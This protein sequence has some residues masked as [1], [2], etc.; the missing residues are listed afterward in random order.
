MG[1]TIGGAESATAWLVSDSRKR[2]GVEIRARRVGEHKRCSAAIGDAEFAADFAFVADG[3]TESTL[4]W[5]NF[6][7][8]RYLLVNTGAVLKAGQRRSSGL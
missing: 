3:D 2:K 6:S 8:S 7:A 5:P 4:F 1:F